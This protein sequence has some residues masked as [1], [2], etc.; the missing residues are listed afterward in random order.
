MPET[1]KSTDYFLWSKKHIWMSLNDKLKETVNVEGIARAR[2][3]EKSRKIKEK[4]Y[5]KNN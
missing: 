1:R 4:Q 3:R 5:L 2:A